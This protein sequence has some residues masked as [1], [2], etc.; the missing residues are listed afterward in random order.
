MSANDRTPSRLPFGL[1]KNIAAL[2]ILGAAVLLFVLLRLTRPDAQVPV[3]VEPVYT[4]RT[5][6]VSPAALSP[7]LRLYGRVVS[8]QRAQLSAPVSADVDAVHVQDGDRFSAGDVLI[9]LDPEEAE[10]AVSQARGNL[11]QIEAQLQLDRSQRAANRNALGHERELL[12][13]SERA[14]AR[15]VDLHRKNLL[16][17]AD[18]DAT[19][20]N[21]QRQKLAVEQR[22]LAVQQADALTA[23]LQ[24]QASSAE[25]SL[26]RA[27]L[28]LQRTQVIAPFSGAVIQTQVAVGDRVNPGQILVEIYATDTLDIRAQIPNRHL[29]Q[30][31]AAARAK[32]RL[33]AVAFAGRQRIDAVFSRLS[34]SASGGGQDA[35]FRI[36]DPD[37]A[38]DSNVSLELELPPEPDAVAVPTNAIY[39]LSR[40]FRVREQRLESLPVEILG[41]YLPAGDTDLSQFGQ[42]VLIRAPEL[43]AGDEIVISQLPNAVNGLKVQAISP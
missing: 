2:I 22:E 6:A 16:S 39:D 38:V 15:A 13:L 43:S 14:V 28:D 11:Q 29:A 35:Y 1:S 37:V 30:I 4:V 25:A 18:L 34:G 5:Q 20:Q 9:D 41:D 7:S 36:L 40:V 26:R 31:Q 12:S 23:Q 17:D 21:L 19:K 24:A 32:A 42:Q 33:P 3:Q 27:E 10:I 8:P